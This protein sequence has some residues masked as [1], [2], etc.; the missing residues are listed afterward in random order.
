[1][2]IILPAL[3]CYGLLAGSEASAQQTFRGERTTL[4]ETGEAR[5]DF[6][7]RKPTGFAGFRLGR[8]YPRLDSDIFDFVTEELTL[9]KSDFRSW[10]LGFDGGFS[11]NEWFE[12]IFSLDTSARE[13]NSEFRYY[14]DEYGMPIT[15]RTTFSQVPLT[16]GIRFLPMPRGREVGKYAY[17]PSPVVPFL[18]GGAGILWYRF[19]QHGYFVD[20][21][22]LEIFR[23]DLESSGSTPVIYLG[24]GADIRIFRSVY[25]TLDLR[26]SWANDDLE[27]YFV[28]FEPMDLSGLR[29][30]AGFHW[31]Y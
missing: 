24:G 13:K 30:T 19:N 26:Y 18:N 20:S 3:M 12:I 16:A 9:E 22:T 5:A 10:D 4:N 28:G 2:P 11:L 8:F 7:F 1:M 29:L 27:G 21:T 15:Q 14:I 23:A 17:L 6:L 25:M 31:H